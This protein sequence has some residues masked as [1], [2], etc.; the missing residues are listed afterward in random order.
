[1]V[2]RFSPPMRA[3]S[4]PVMPEN[5]CASKFWKWWPGAESNHRHTDYQVRK[6]LAYQY[7]LGASFSGGRGS[8]LR[9]AGPR[10]AVPRRLFERTHVLPDVRQPPC[11]SA[12]VAVLAEGQHGPRA[13][14]SDQVRR[15]C[16]KPSVTLE[17]AH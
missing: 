2:G 12:L 4:P 8:S 1:M 5:S 9:L 17:T 15:T 7:R 10:P 3:D 13:A 6:E 11:R 16:A 14:R